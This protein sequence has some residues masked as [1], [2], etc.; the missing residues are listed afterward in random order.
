M[1][2]KGEEGL[3]DEDDDDRPR[4]RRTA[5][6]TTAP[7]V[8]VRRVGNGEE[9]RHGRMPQLALPERAG[10]GSV[11]PGAGADICGA[12]VAAP[13][14]G[15]SSGRLRSAWVRLEQSSRFG[16]SW[17]CL[18]TLLGPSWAGLERRGQ[19]WG[20]LVPS[21]GLPGGLIGGLGD[22]LGLSWGGLGPSRGPPGPAWGRLGQSR[23]TLGPSWGSLGGLTGGLGD[24]L[25]L[26][27]GGLGPPWAVLE[28]SWAVLGL[29]W[30]PHGRS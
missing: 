27:W 1:K 4:R 26:S 7:G 18:G 28:H 17:G 14:S 16:I 29:S 12:V 5:T 8:S 25:G 22:L 3:G 9:Q 10:M 23:G 15:A 30:G 21:W 2:E 19:S 11:P 24:L 20:T 13:P 6:A